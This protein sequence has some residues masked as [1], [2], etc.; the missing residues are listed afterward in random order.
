MF[1]HNVVSFI[2]VARRPIAWLAA[3]LL[4]SGGAA[5]ETAVERGGYL[6]NTIMACGNC[7]TPKDANGVPI[8]SRA[9]SGGLSFDTPNFAGT[10]SNI[11][12]DRETGIGNWSDADIKLALTGGARPGNARLPGVPLADVMPFHLSRRYC[13]AMLMQSL[14]ICAL[15][16]QCTAKYRHR[17]TRGWQT[18]ILIPTPRP[19]SPR[20]CFSDKCGAAPIS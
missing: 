12:P 13:R 16:P 18:T 17:R 11:T 19:D 14:P 3:F 10:A 9:L 6:V 8:L 4:V 7:H 15:Y 2:V 5:A 20:R 1:P